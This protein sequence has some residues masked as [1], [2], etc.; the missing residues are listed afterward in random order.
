MEEMYEEILSQLHA[1]NF[2]VP[3]HLQ[4]KWRS[5]PSIHTEKSTTTITSCLRTAEN[6]Y[7]PPT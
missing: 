1:P 3:R 6:G 4:D 5:V 2:S 7:D